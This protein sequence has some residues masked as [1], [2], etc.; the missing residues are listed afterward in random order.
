MKVMDCSQGLEY[1]KVN[2]KMGRYK[3]EA[4]MR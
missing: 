1:L 2:K 4:K 3:P